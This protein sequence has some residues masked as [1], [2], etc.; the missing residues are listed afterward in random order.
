VW[1]QFGPPSL[2]RKPSEQGQHFTYV[3]PTSGVF[4]APLQSVH[5]ASIVAGVVTNDFGKAATQI[6]DNYIQYAKDTIKNVGPQILIGAL[7][8][9]VMIIAAYLFLSK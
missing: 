7:L 1:N 5:N 8:V 6:V 2:S 4:A 3:P 9:I